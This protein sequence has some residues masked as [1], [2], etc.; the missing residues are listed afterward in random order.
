MVEAECADGEDNDGD[1]APDC[2]DLDCAGFCARTLIVPLPSERECAD[3]ED[4]DGDGAVDCD[5]ADCVD[6]EACNIAPI[7]YCDDRA[8][9]NRDGLI[10]CEDDAGLDF[11]GCMGLDYAGPY[12]LTER[13]CSDGAD[14]DGDHA[15]DCEDVDCEYREP[16]YYP[17]YAMP[18]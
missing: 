3:G 5:D 14:D 7:E 8:D 11:V 10:D 13:D 9:N 2:E 4:N 16:C 18:F 1:H 17:P 15:I 12:D 6:R